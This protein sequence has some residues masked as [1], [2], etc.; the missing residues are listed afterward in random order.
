M[1]KEME[2]E[3]NVNRSY[4]AHDSAMMKS[5]GASD[6]HNQ[7]I[8]SSFS[9]QSTFLQN[10]GS[11]VK[12]LE[13]FSDKTLKV[14]W[15]PRNHN[16][17]FGG[18]KELAYLWNV[19]VNIENSVVI[20]DLPHVSPT[21]NLGNLMHSKASISAIDWKPDGSM[22]ITAATDGVCRMWDPK[23]ELKVIMYNDNAMPLK[24]KDVYS[25]PNGTNDSSQTYVAVPDDIDAI[26]D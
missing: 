4:D 8:A 6:V 12:I 1:D 15:N 14:A 26:S 22:F 13:S 7:N 19:D 17:A 16:L 25:H 10:N 21:Q 23:G 20:Q 9:R 11:E 3:K 18:D 24:S 5:K 2:E